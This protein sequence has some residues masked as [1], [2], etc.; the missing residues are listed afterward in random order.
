[1]NKKLLAAAMATAMLFVGCSSSNGGSEAKGTENTVTDEDIT[2]TVTKDADG[3]ITD[4]NIDQFDEDGSSKKDKGEEYGMKKVSGIGKEWN[5]Q[6]EFLEDYMV[7]NG[8]DAV[9]MDESGYADSD[10][11]KTGCTINIAKYVEVAK[12]AAE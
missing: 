2:V 1:M 6:I 3:K 10:D 4:V 8:I 11:V 12:K 7:E 9:T 5:E